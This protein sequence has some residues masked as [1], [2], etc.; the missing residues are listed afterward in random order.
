MRYNLNLN[1]ALNPGKPLGFAWSN[2]YH[3]LLATY[4]YKV[5]FIP[6]AVQYSSVHTLC[7]WPAV[8]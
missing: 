3:L 8:V 7:A 5:D 6:F 4:H 2:S 1:I